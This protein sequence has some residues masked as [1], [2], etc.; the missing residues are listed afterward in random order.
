MTKLS[1]NLNKIALIRNSRDSDF[2]RL[3]DFAEICIDAGAHGLTIHPRPDQ[4]HARYSDVPDLVRLATRHPGVEVN[5][6]GYPNEKFLE[7]VIAAAPD[8]CTLVPDD[9]DQLTS[10]HGW[11]TLR[12]GDSL[13]RIIEQLHEHNIRTSIF[14]DPEVSMLESALATGTDRIELYTESYAR[15]FGTN[16]EDDVWIQFDRVARAA[17]DMGLGVNAGHDLNQDNLPR[18]LQI[19][20]ILEVSIGHALTVESLKSGFSSTVA[21]Y[22]ELIN[23]TAQ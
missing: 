3:L 12:H 7:V 4:R 2:P 15:A 11:D 21:D 18:F 20:G 22:L 6:E 23:I 17:Q 9:P 10:D 1:V 8:Q 16:A 14:L 13:S 5:I 19:P